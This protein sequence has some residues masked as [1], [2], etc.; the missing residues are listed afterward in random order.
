[1][2]PGRSRMRGQAMVEFAICLPILLSLTLGLVAVGVAEWRRSDAD[3]ALSNLASELPEGWESMP[4]AELVRALL[5]DGSSLDEDRLT[6]TDADVSV[7]AS[8]DT[9]ASGRLATSLGGGFVKRESTWVVVSADV[10]YDLDDGIWPLVSGTY[11]RHVERR[12][13][14]STR[15][16]VG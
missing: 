7:S 4:D 3:H 13:L 16:E 15:T 5:L 10:D 9:D 1:M 2:G 8:S 11:S 6:V 14:A 12:Y